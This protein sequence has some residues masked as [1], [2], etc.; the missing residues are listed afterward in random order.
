MKTIEKIKPVYI[1]CIM[2]IA[3]F[4][5]PYNGIAQRFGH[6]GGGGFHGGGGG[7]HAAPV[8]RGGGFNGGARNV[9]AHVYRAP[10]PAPRF[11][12][13]PGVRHYD[14]AYH[15][16]YGGGHAY[17]YHPYHPYIWGPRWH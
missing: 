14:N 15:G 7:G 6:G 2:L 5:M 11:S 4:M 1:S 13:G 9:D 8:F 16:V 3:A 12:A 10:A 17:F